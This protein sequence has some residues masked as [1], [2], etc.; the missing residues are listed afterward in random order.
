M[1]AVIF[2]IA[3]CLLAVSVT[4]IDEKFI[5]CKVCDRAIAHIW[6][7][8]VNLRAHCKTH[9]TDPRCDI[10]NMHRHGVEEMV[11]DVCA[12]LPK[13]HQSLVS[14]EFELVTHESPNHDQEIID[15]IEKT[16][17]RWV[18]EEHTVTAMM[19][20]NLDAQK[21]THVILHKLQER[22]CDAACKPE[23][24]PVNEEADVVDEM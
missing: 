4:A 17:L 8:G 20:A 7:Q 6:N 10:S 24:P 21:P 2:V 12:D 13:T 23:Q 11:K 19:Y 22:F 15:A 9:G 16:C 5:R 3:L 1:K 14:S 18:H